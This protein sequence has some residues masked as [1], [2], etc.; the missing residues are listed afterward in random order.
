VNHLRQ[1]LSPV[2]PKAY[3]LIATQAREVLEARLAARKLVDFD[4]PRGYEYSAVPLGR[5][6]RIQV[7]PN[8]DARLR[9]VLPLLELRVPFELQLAELDNVDRGADDIELEPVAEAARKL[10]DLED[11]AVFY[12]VEAAGIGGLLPTSTQ[13]R[14]PVNPDFRDFTDQVSGAI[15]QLQ[16]AGVAGPY[17][18]ALDEVSYTNLLRSTG[19]GGYPTLNHV[20]KLVEGPAV[21][22]PSI[23]GA[24]V[25]SLRGGDF[26]LTIGQDTSIGYLSHDQEKVRMYLEETLTFRS[27]S[28]EAVVALPYA[29]A[30]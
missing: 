22:A 1:E 15:A 27:L 30:R 28:P 19:P 6:G 23:S 4:G 14:L 24:L 8:I 3:E 2:L 17:A 11:K 10:A 7:G 21:F 13:P 9:Q 5:A 29:G 12:G 18:I 16:T 26:V 20:R 25:I